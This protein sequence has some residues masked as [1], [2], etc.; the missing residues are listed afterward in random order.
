MEALRSERPSLLLAEDAAHV[1]YEAARRGPT[2][3]TCFYARRGTLASRRDEILRL[4]CAIDR[5]EKF[6]DDALLAD[7][8][9][10][11]IVH[12]HGTGRLREALGKY[13]RQHPIVSSVEPAAENEGGRGATIV[14]LKD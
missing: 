10:L 11:R 13:L 4:V 3:Y 14:E 5:T 2:S 7:E 12:G 6:L 1:W 9:R 8:K